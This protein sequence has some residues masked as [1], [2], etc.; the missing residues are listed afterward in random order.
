[1]GDRSILWDAMHALSRVLVSAAFAGIVAGCSS[2]APPDLFPSPNDNSVAGKQV[3]CDVA[4]DKQPTCPG[5]PM[6]SYQLLDFQ[7]KSPRYNQ[8]YGLEV[9]KG[10]TTLVALLA[11]WC[12]YCQSQ[13]TQLNK[14]HQDLVASG[15]DINFVIINKAD[16]IRPEYQQNF[17]NLT[18]LPLLQDTEQINAWGQQG[19]VKDDMFIYDAAGTLRAYLA[20]NGPVDTNMSGSAGRDNV[21]SAVLTV[22]AK[23]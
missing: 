11:G 5:E 15:H 1:M 14:I 12:P 23:K 17:V 8:T 10:K 3:T 19:G 22:D 13:L 6:P 20:A 2:S 4:S 18:D 16:A 7:P 21:R 9:F